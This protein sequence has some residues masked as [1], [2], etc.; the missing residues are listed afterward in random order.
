MKKHPK[1]KII[2]R[3]RSDSSKNYVAPSPISNAPHYNQDK[4]ISSN[5]NSMCI[6]L[7]QNYNKFNNSN[8]ELRIRE[9]AKRAYN[10]CIRSQKEFRDFRK[11]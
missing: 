6:K 7:K 9:K 2:L 10:E 1:A 3:K 11:D 5:I 8:V 4:M